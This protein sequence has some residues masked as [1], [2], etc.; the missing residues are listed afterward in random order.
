[1]GKVGRTGNRRERAPGNRRM[2]EAAVLD[3]DRVVALAPDDQGGHRLEQVEAVGR[4]DALPVNVDHRAQRLQEG[5]PGASI[6]ER[7]QRP[8]EPEQPHDQ[9]QLVAPERPWH[10][11]PEAL[12]ERGQGA[13]CDRVDVLCPERV[14]L[15]GWL[16][17]R[18]VG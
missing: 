17:H 10:A 16:L 11:A 18:L 4:A 8:G 13:G 1:M 9:E 15:G 3:R 6:L 12:L 5:G 2:G 14:G 7:A